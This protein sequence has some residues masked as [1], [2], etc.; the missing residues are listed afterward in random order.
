MKNYKLLSCSL[1]QQ[2]NTKEP[3]ALGKKS[4]TT[5]FFAQKTWFLNLAIFFLL[6]VGNSSVAQ[7]TIINPTT[8]GSFEGASFAAD[9]W[10]ALNNA[11]AGASWVQSTGATAGF[12]GAQAAYITTNEGA[13]PPPHAY[14]NTLARVSALYKDVTIP[15]GEASIALS[16]RW[17]ALGESGYDRL[18]VWAVPTDYVPLNGTA[19]MTTTGVAP[20]GRLQLGAGANGYQ[21]SSVWTTANI[22]VPAAYAGTSFRLVF[23]WRNDGSGGSNPPIAI[24]NVSLTSSCAGVVAIAPSPVANTSATA[25]WTAFAGATSYDVRYRAIGAPTWID[26]NGVAGT[27]TLLAPLNASSNYEYQVKAN[28]PVCNAYS[29]SVTFSTVCNPSSIPY[30]EGF[31]GVTVPAFPLCASSS[32]PLTRSTTGTGAA[33]RTG[34]IYQ[35]IRWTPTVNKYIY[36]APLSLNAA[37][38]YDMGAWYLTDGITGWTSIKLYA[39]NTPSVTGAT[40]LTTVTGATNTTYQRLKGTYTPSTTGVYFF[41]IEVIHTSGPNDMSI[42]DMFAELTPSCVS[43]TNLSTSS[44]TA[45]SAV[46]NWTASISNPANGYDYFYSTTNTAP[47]ALT[48]PSGSVMAGITTATLAGLTSDAT[49]YYWV[50]SKCSGS[51]I[52]SWSPIAGTFVTGYCIPTGGTTY[53]LT[54]VTTTGGATNISNPTGSTGGY[55]NYSATNSCSSTFGQPVSI[56]L[57]TNTSTHYFYGW[58]DWNNDFDFN[59]VGETIFATTTYTASY[60]GVINIPAGTPAGNYRMRVANS[61]VG[62]I[63]AC[64]PGPNSEYEDYTFTVIAQ[65]P[66][67][68]TPDAATVTSSIANVCVSGLV[69]LTATVPFSANSGII[70]QWYNTAGAIL[71]ATATT[72]TTPVLTSAESY[73]F[74]STCVN[75]G[76]FVNSNTVVIG[77]N[78]PTVVSTTSNTRCGVGS[79]NL[80]ATVSA[81]A[82]AVWYNVATGGTPLFTGTTFA[83]P[84]IAATTTYYVEASEGG[85]SLV[86]GKL[87]TTGADGTNTIGGLY[88]TA[89]TAFNLNSV[90]MYPQGAGTNTIVLYAGSTTTGTP[91]YTNNYTFTGPTSTGVTVPLNW[92]IEPGTYTIYQ[93]VSN[94]NCYRDTTA[95]TYPYNIGSAC[96]ITEGTLGGFYYFFYNWTISTGCASART[97]VTATV[98]VPPTLTLSAASAT[99]C[100]N[101]STTAVTVATGAADYDSY[102]WSPSTGV[103]GNSTIGWTFSPISTTTYTLAA[104][105]TTGTLCGASATFVV[106]VNPLPAVLNI[107]P[108]TASICSDVIQA[109]TTT[110]GSI[111]I[112]GKVGSGTAN[113]T[114]S[115][116][117]KNNWGGSKTQAL[118]T[119]AELTALGMQAGQRVNSIGYVALNSAT[120]PLNNFTIT[121]GFIA[122]S[123]IGSSFDGGATTTVLAPT[124][125]TANGP[126]NIDFELANP[127]LW[128]GVSSLLIETCYNNNDSGS[129]SSLSVESTQVATGLNIYYTADNNATVCSAP[130][131]ATSSTSRPNLR[132]S[133]LLSA[134][135]T[136]TPVTNL[137]TDAAATVPYTGT[138]ATTV[139]VK[140]ATASSQVYTATATIAATGCSTTATTSVIVNATAAPTVSPQTFCNTATVNDLVANGTAI[141]W[142]TALTGGTDLATTVGLVSGEYFVSQTL[143][144]C[145]STRTSVAVTV[146]SVNTPTGDA[147]QTFCGS[148]FLSDLVVVGTGI[149]LYTAAT[150]GT[151]YPNALWSS[152]G[153]VNGTSYYAT[154]AENGCE[155][156][157]RLQITA[158]INAVPTA[159]NVSAQ[160]F[161]TGAT[162]ADLVP[163][164]SAIQWYADATGGTALAQTT[165]LVAGTYYASQ[166]IAGCESARS[167][168][169]ITLNALPTATVTLTGDTLTVSE[170]GA[171]YQ[172]VLCDGS[173]LTPIAGATNQELLVTTVGSY[174]VQVTKNGCT[175]TSDCF[176]VTTLSNTQFDIAKLV[177][178]PNP[179]TDVL[180]ISHTET[181]SSI[182]VYDITGRVLRNINANT[183]EVKIDMSN[184]PASVYI[185]KVIMENTSG[186]FKVIK[187]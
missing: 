140:S 15:A 17:I 118:Y 55:A 114:A 108:A 166:T 51:D 87:S 29:P 25:N 83:T 149:K 125:Y 59:D 180:A 37:T 182:Q 94:A 91:I 106:N 31:E 112:S 64:G 11:T 67:T 30:F 128:D 68:G 86:G 75:S 148:G 111:A 165:A 28:G 122:A 176:E 119:A 123:T 78:Q 161:C 163:T 183:N 2:F 14:V 141:K 52:S 96:T 76:L 82:S 6:A 71:G 126:G 88:F 139:Y 186:E 92:V 168:V 153:L 47:D 145:E 136:W 162:V 16:F 40:L 172:W 9:G 22:T 66:C 48:T 95:I 5:A 144:G 129:G 39:N 45:N 146:Y 113:N 121:A 46:I 179:V 21:G 134:N 20:T 104:S 173:L 56:T 184:M 127:I 74:Q 70:Y 150:G 23:Q 175:V 117:F 110:G 19:S 33:P 50:R 101:A 109:L 169:V 13:S 158:V 84:S 130:G 60:T 137:F 35:N 18:Q 63:T 43:P 73:Y 69:T 151:E 115:T 100:A 79:V 62:A 105:Q 156:A 7:T 131:I 187:K 174:A 155:S 164:G 77:V 116:P 159:P 61:Y 177:Y 93:S 27:S 107:T 12:I 36:S 152:I 120:T 53:F 58:I 90:V 1:R 157:V 54:N 99:I 103:S 102:V 181:I 135:V 138:N 154:Q 171:L 42:D 185:V 167:S 44:V 41:I 160:S 34:T 26:I 3:D 170:E 97:A 4:A 72:Y 80:N 65:D 98:T 38:N 49:Y 24:D 32:H 10:T 8:D 142:Y 143:N 81:A 89:N 85:S 147:T 132:I 124:S 57:D 133:A 178:Y